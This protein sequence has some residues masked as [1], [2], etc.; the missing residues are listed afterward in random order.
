VLGQES[1]DLPHQRDDLG[2][3]AVSVVEANDDLALADK[4]LKLS[5]PR[6]LRVNCKFVPV[7]HE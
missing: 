5:A 3:R 7:L 1:G 6:R 4:R 2:D